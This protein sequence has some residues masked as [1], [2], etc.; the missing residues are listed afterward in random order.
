MPIESPE[1]AGHSNVGILAAGV[2]VSAWGLAGVIAKD[3]DMGGVAIGAYRFTIYGLVVAVVMAI[4]RAPLTMRALRASFA[5]GMA[6]GL[7]VAFFFSAIKETTIAN[8]TVIGA[9]QPVVVSLIA[10]RFFGERI[11]RRDV[12]LAALALGGVLVVVRQVNHL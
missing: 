8:A 12:A 2:A 3:I 5:G 9:L 10:A 11:A 1:D 4:R 7:D 6:L